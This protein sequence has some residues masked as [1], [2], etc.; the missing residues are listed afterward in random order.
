M[1]VTKIKIILYAKSYILASRL[2]MTRRKK[3]KSRGQLGKRELKKVTRDVG[4][5]LV[6]LLESR[7]VPN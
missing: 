6:E 1:T 2:E 3:G 4:K 5:I 7:M